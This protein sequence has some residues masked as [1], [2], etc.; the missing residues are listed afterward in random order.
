MLGTILIIILTLR[1]VCALPTW[2]YSSGGGYYP[3]ED[4]RHHFDHRYYFGPAGT[5][6]SFS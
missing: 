2:H 6:I 3:G 5:N 4:A 1:L